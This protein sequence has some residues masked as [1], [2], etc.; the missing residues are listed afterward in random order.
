PVS[1]SA[2]RRLL[3]DAFLTLVF[4]T[5]EDVRNVTHLGRQVT[6]RQ[7][8]ALEAR[9]CRCERCGSMSLLD[10]DHHQGW[11]LNHD[12]RVA[13]LSWAGRHCH[14]LRTRHDLIFEGSRGNKRL[15]RRDGTDWDPPP[16]ERGPAGS[17]PPEQAARPEQ[18][19]LFTLAD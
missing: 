16:G 18:G 19:D 11:V 17:D 4:E 9:G 6:A 14:D 10:I 5:G 2:I 7:R 15:V 1:V 12:P 13:R 8:T 3:S